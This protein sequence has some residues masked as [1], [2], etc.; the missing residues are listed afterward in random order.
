[1]DLPFLF[2]GRVYALWAPGGKLPN[3]QPTAVGQF[4][5][6]HHLR[7]VANIKLRLLYSECCELRSAYDELSNDHHSPR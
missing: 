2:S 5:D 7:N 6:T 4:Q 1:M 3:G